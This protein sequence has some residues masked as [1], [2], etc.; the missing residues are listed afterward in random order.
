MR[1]VC[2]RRTMTTSAPS[3]AFSMRCTTRTFGR[4]LFEFARHPHRRAAERDPHAELAEQVNIRAR[5]AAV[6]NVAK[7][8]D[9]PAFELALAVADRQGVEQGLRGMLVRA[10]AGIEHGNFEALGDEFR[11]A[12]RSVAN[13][14]AIGA[15]GFE[16]ANRVDQRFALFQ[17]RGFGLQSHGIRAEAGRGG[18]ES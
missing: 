18:G 6:K 13:H 1:S 14:D 3:S 15:H 8:R 2:T 4:E 10:V 17:A 7:D 5:H 9:V 12:G 16:R 11:R